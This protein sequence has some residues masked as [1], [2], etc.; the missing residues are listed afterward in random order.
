MPA[1]LTETDVFVLL[2][3]RRRRLAL[4]I[5]Q[6]YTTP[7]TVRELT[8]LIGECEYED[9]SADS[10]HAIHISLS[11]NHLPRLEQAD[12]VEYDRDGGTVSPG[13]NFDVL[14][15]ALEGMSGSDNS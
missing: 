9:P 11:H 13:L 3:K 8:E 15:D 4:R 1:E 14:T 6:E 10:L 5:L 7:L 12:I 2:S